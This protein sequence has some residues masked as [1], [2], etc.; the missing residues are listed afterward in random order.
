ML[1][2][3]LTY[4]EVLRLENIFDRT[5]TD[6]VTTQHR[7][8][9]KILDVPNEIVPLVDSLS[10]V[11]LFNPMFVRLFFFFRRRAGTVLLRDRDNPLSAEIV[12]DPLLALFPFVADQPDVLDLLRS[13]WNARWKTV[14]NKSEPEQAAS[15]FDIFMNTAYCIYRT[16]VMPAYTIWD[17]RCLAARQKVFNKCVDML[18]EYN[19]ATHFLLTQPSRPINIFDYSFDLLGPHALD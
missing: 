11:L 2:L 17:S 19:S 15:F 8:V 18:R 10:D 14:K 1:T 13:L 12:S 5:I 9:L 6:G 7:V 16:A 3:D 4:A